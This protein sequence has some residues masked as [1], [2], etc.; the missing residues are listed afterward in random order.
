MSAAETDG[1]Q[2]LLSRL[3]EQ[4]R[5]ERTL[6]AEV[7]RAE[8][9]FFQA[10]PLRMAQ[11]DVAHIEPSNEV[12]SARH[13]FREWYLIE[14]ESQVLGT[15]PVQCL[16]MSDADRETLSDSL[17]GVF[18]VTG[19]N[20]AEY[21]IEDLQGGVIHDLSR[22]EGVDLVPGDVL[23]GRLYVGALDVF[24]GSPALGCQRDAS[25][26]AT[27]FQ[28]DIR[29]LD[30]DRR[31]TQAEIELL[32]FRGVS[33][34]SGT[35]APETAIPLEH[36]EADLETHLLKGG[37]EEGTLSATSISNALRAAPRPGMIMNP[38]LEKIAFDSAVD[39]QAVQ[40][41]LLKIWEYH[42]RVDGTPTPL[43]L[44][45]LPPEA[46]AIVPHP[47]SDPSEDEMAATPDPDENRPGL[48]AEVARRIQ[49]GLDKAEDID[50]VFEDVDRMVGVGGVGGVGGAGSRG[51][52]RA[53]A[54][55]SGEEREESAAFDGDLRPL[56][57]EYLWETDGYI[58]GDVEILEQFVVT[59]CEAPVPRLDLE[60]IDSQ[61][62]LRLLLQTY[63]GA[64]P[65]A[66]A[67]EVGRVFAGL[68]RFYT[69]V[70]K[71]QG[72]EVQSVIESVQAKLVDEVARLEA[73]GMALTVGED[74]SPAERGLYR[75]VALGAG[76]IEVLREETDDL[77]RVQVEDSE[78]VRVDDFLLGAVRMTG[79]R[80]GTFAGMVV[81]IP[82]SA[83]ELLG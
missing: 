25:A 60:S 56:I 17:V 37:V 38:M 57:T 18:R 65:G 75:V 27:A 26:L 55:R 35:T 71:T 19:G 51:A 39:I 14:R 49:E 77:A 3:M 10:A 6:A 64:A 53:A 1:I 79:D 30:L 44:P 36:L 5:A 21:S 43:P 40:Q 62:L 70:T 48:G 45:P 23:I 13:R 81:A 61:D 9:E 74:A 50:A 58:G 22:I 78:D 47:A 76:W 12:L 28:N 24:V 7:L 16:A 52:A 67:A 66:R 42:R 59:Q 32:M 41:L 29:Q 20:H 73:A 33:D 15:V 69:W 63:L 80:T 11:V 54:A 82:A 2:H 8:R 46:A 68:G 72:Y 4:V 31:L 83:R 34:G